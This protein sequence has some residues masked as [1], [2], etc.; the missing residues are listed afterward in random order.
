[1]GTKSNLG[2]KDQKVSFRPEEQ[3]KCSPLVLD[4]GVVLAEGDLAVAVERE[5][6]VVGQLGPLL[7]GRLTIEEQA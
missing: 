3:G 4:F 7:V 1:M 5:L 6:V 2:V